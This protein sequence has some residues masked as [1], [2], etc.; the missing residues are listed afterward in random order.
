MFIFLNTTM[1]K[2]STRLLFVKADLLT[3]LNLGLNLT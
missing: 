1:L 3:F 2:Y